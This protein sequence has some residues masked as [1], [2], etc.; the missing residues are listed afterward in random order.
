ML[1]VA[2]DDKLH[3]PYRAAQAVSD[4]DAVRKILLDAGADAVAISGAG[5]TII[6]FVTG[7]TPNSSFIKA[8]QIAEQTTE[9]LTGLGSRTTPQALSFAVRGYMPL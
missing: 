4:F 1:H 6:A 8:E 2:I 7:F 3:Q 9:A 5:P